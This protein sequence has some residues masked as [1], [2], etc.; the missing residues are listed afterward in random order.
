MTLE[1]LPV[2]VDRLRE[3]PD[4][5]EL[6]RAT[7]EELR[8]RL[9]RE[10]VGEPERPR[11][12]G[13]G[14]AMRP[15]RSCAHG[16][17]GREAQHRLGV[18]GRLGVVGKA[19]EIRSALGSACERCECFPVQGEPRVGRQRFLDGEAGELVA[20]CH[21]TGL[22]REH[23][24]RQ[25]FLEAVGGVTR[26]RVEEPELGL[27]RRDRDC[28]EQRPRRGAHTRHAGEHRVADRGRDLASPAASTSVTKNGLPAVVR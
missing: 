17:L 27:R 24:G 18:A 14:L 5:A 1:R 9:G 10:A 20:E 19:R 7:V 3:L 8:P 13:G 15:D 22:G 16:G 26:E 4:R 11:V 12:L 21:A 2:H 28:L 25:A 23:P 6:A